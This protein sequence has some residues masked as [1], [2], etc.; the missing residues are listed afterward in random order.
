[1]NT[2]RC[3]LAAGFVVTAALCLRGPAQDMD[4]PGPPG[5]A[6]SMMKTLNQVEP[7]GAISD[8]PYSITTSGVYYLTRNLTGSGSSSGITV[9]T[10]NVEIDLNGFALAGIPGTQHGIYV[11]SPSR[12]GITVRNGTVS[13]WGGYGI[14]GAYAH[15]S[16]FRDLNLADNNDDGLYVGTFCFVENCGAYG[17]GGNGIN[18]GDGSTVRE[19]KAADNGSTGILAYRASKITECTSL[20]NGANGIWARYNSVV[21]NCVT[22]S[23]ALHGVNAQ[24]ASM[25]EGNYCYQNLAAGVYVNGSGGQILNNCVTGNA[26]GF[27]MYSTIGGNFLAGNKASLN[28]VGYA[29]SQGG[30]HYGTVVTSNDMGTA[31]FTVGNPWVNFEY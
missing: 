30:D 10:N 27:V 20:R 2:P 25:V 1:M 16:R 28:D 26:T 31:G 24:Y 8:L 22:W 3:L 19:C 21:R 14:Q 7:R 29:F 13:D 17:N 4:P 23:N 6:I 11:P 5:S 18:A 12:N 15:R 9:Y